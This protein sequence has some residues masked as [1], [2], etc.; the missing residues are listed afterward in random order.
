MDLWL[1]ISLDICLWEAVSFTLNYSRILA[2][3]EKMK[4]GKSLE[5][6]SS[7]KCLLSHLQV[8]MD[9]GNACGFWVPSRNLPGSPISFN[10]SLGVA[11]KK[12]R[13][14]LVG[15]P[16]NRLPTTDHTPHRVHE[17]QMRG[18]PWFT[19]SQSPFQTPCICPIISSELSV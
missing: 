10:E 14:V 17:P 5:H 16:L 6:V 19:I 11:S 1:L 7:R 3:R 8:G 12:S 13:R 18:R 2:H 15:T 9:G 4:L